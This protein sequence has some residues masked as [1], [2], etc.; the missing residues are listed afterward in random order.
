MLLLAS[1][2][3]IQSLVVPTG[4]VNVGCICQSMSVFVSLSCKCMDDS[5]LLAFNP[6]HNG[7]YIPNTLLH[8]PVN[9]V[10]IPTIV[11]VSWSSK[12]RDDTCLLAFNPQQCPIFLNTLLYGPVNKVRIPTSTI[13][14]VS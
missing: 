12:C 8:G 9:K 11:F 6:Q 3:S 1:F 5:N 7:H 10:S 13:V 2:P 14:F 4:P